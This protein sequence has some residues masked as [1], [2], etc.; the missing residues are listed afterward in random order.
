MKM[1][2]MLRNTNVAE[3]L[4]FYLAV[5]WNPLLFMIFAENIIWFQNIWVRWKGRVK[6]SGKQFRKNQ[7]VV[8][9]KLMHIITKLAFEWY[10]FLLLL[11]GQYF[12]QAFQA[13]ALLTAFRWN[14]WILAR[15][16]FLAS[17]YKTRW[18]HHFYYKIMI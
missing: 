9:I 8:I 18:L 15:N 17:F 6:T 3:I 16:H 2:Q 7:D 11:L 13:R 12:L 4:V 10:P 5:K 14:N 1:S